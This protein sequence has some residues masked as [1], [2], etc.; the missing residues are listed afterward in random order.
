MGAEQIE[1]EMT[2]DNCGGIG[3]VDGDLCIVCD[4]NG[5]VLTDIGER[6]AQ[7]IDLRLGRMLRKAG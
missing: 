6:I 1:L 5:K 4:G 2:C 3:S 7:L